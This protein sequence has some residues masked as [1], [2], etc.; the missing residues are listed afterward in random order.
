[1][2]GELIADLGEFFDGFRIEPF[3]DEL[4]DFESGRGAFPFFFELCF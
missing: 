1:M 4:I 2:C 3:V